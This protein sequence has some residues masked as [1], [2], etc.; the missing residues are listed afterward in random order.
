MSSPGAPELPSLNL[1]RRYDLYLM[2]R[3]DNEW[4]VRDEIHFNSRATQ[5]PPFERKAVVLKERSEI[6]FTQPVTLRL[7]VWRETESGSTGDISRPRSVGRTFCRKNRSVAFG[8]LRRRTC[9]FAESGVDDRRRKNSPKRMITVITRESGGE[10]RVPE[11]AKRLPPNF[12]PDQTV[13]TLRRVSAIFLSL[14][15]PPDQRNFLALTHLWECRRNF[16][17]PESERWRKH[18]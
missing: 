9:Q 6:K 16:Y 18:K 3:R 7:L 5:C 8:G 11:L 1:S 15:L 14:H 17:I 2:G 13:D 10:P 12:P 4:P